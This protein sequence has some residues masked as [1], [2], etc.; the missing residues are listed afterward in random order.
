MDVLIVEPLEPEVMQWLVERHAVRYAPDLAR[1]PRAFRQALFN[2]RSLIVP[3][4]VAIDAQALHYAPVLRAVGRISAGAENIDA[5]A[6]AKAGVEVV[7]SATA[8]AVAEAEF[9][10]G[11]LLAMLRRVPVVSADGLLVGR[12][13]GGA[14][15]GLVGMVPAARSLAQLLGA[16][17]A[18][19]VG[20]DPS[21]HASDGLWSRWKVEPLG[22]RDL[23]EQSDGVCVQLSSFTRYHGLLG[24]R[25]LPFCK[26]NQ[27]LVSLSH[28]N[29]FDEASLAEVL[30]SGRMAAAWFDS[31][32]PGALDPG[33]ALHEI[34][35]L[36]VT[37]RVAST[38][39]ESRIRAAWAV[40]R[41]IDELL[42][43]AQTGGPRDFRATT[44][45]I[46]DDDAVSDAD[47]LLDLEA[48]E[49]SA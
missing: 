20:Y 13:L 4:S 6:C 24:E 3:P 14:T 1:D 31:L 26:P 38:T 16:F 23:M 47:D 17:G 35:T 40:A 45:D 19:V 22:L 34:D 28:S 29:V 43:A 21:V 5:D 7:R 30:G 32:E 10:I 8:S 44:D 9:V 42:N 36:Q 48:G 15:V 33:R 2:V 37:P 18:R 27:V 25:F 11:A 41:R 46:A 12:E 39:R 49:A